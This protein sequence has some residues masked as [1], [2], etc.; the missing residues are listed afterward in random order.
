MMPEAMKLPPTAHSK[1]KQGCCGGGTAENETH[2]NA[3]ARADDGCCGR[4]PPV[5]T[6][7]RAVAPTQGIIAPRASDRHTSVDSN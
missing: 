2:E 7:R 1:P 4:N 5:A 6:A 3:S